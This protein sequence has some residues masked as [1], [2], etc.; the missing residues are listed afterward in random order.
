[1]H[2]IG[3]ITRRKMADHCRKNCWELGRKNFG[4][5]EVGR[6]S[7]QKIYPILLPGKKFALPSQKIKTA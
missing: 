2:M 5:G 4:W 7:R 3:L 1:M 6:R